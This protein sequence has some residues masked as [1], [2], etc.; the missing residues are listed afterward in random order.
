MA[1]TK[2][3]TASLSQAFWGEQKFLPSDPTANRMHVISDG[4]LAVSDVPALEV[5]K[6]FD[7][8]QASRFHNLARKLMSATPSA[9][10]LQVVVEQ[11]NADV[12]AFERRSERLA[13]WKLQVPIEGAVG[14]FLDCYTMPVASIGA[15]WLYNI[16]KHKIP[17][18]VQNEI[19]DAIAMLIGLATGSSVDAVIVSRSRKAIAKK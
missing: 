15:A 19:A 9:S 14:A 3:V 13:S 1:L 6:N 8:L 5:A 12:K 18:K 4:L 7:S 16:L 17:K 11:I 2:P 10:E